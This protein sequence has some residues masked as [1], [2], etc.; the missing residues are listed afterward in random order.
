MP[1]HLSQLLNPNAQILKEFLFALEAIPV[2]PWVIDWGSKHCFVF[3]TIRLDSFS[4]PGHLLAESLLFRHL[5]C[6][7]F[8]LKL[9]LFA[10]QTLWRLFLLIFQLQSSPLDL[11]PFLLLSLQ[12]L[13]EHSHYLL[14]VDPL[15]D[16]ALDHLKL[17]CFFVVFLPLNVF[18]V[19][20]VCFCC[21]FWVH[22]GKG[23]EAGKGVLYW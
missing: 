9:G 18:V 21:W 2:H 6:L 8:F 12:L 13:I 14:A 3:P 16:L 11:L 15:V 22:G 5:F 19:V 17:L 10:D 7:L 23:P 4:K 20:G 1:W